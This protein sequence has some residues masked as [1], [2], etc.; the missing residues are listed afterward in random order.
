MPLAL[1]FAVTL[2]SALGVAVEYMSE[3][4]PASAYSEYTILETSVWSAATSEPRLYG[5]TAKSNS[6]VL[7]ATFITTDLLALSPRLPLTGRKPLE[8]V[9]IV[10]GMRDS[11]TVSASSVSVEYSLYQTCR[12]R[13][14]TLKAVL[15]AAYTVNIPFILPSVLL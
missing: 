5:S 3:V 9:E 11:N 2:V 14:F 1:I 6:S 13:L 15:F 4:L 12:K 7:L 10:M 8:L